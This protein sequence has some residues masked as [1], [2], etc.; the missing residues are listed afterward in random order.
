MAG[1]RT[2]DQRLRVFVSSTMKELAAER[3]AVRDSVQRLRLTPVLFELG[4]R[5]HPPRALYQAYLEQSDVFVGIYWQ[6]YGWVAPSAEISGLEDEYRLSGHR[7]R[8]LYVKDPAPDRDP[9]L[10]SLLDEI[11][12]EASLS[13]RSFT[14]A[15]ELGELVENDLAHL[16]S[17]RFAADAD[18]RPDEGRLPAPATPLVGRDEE[19]AVVCSLLRGDAR[20]VTVTGPGGIGKTRVGIR[21]AE[22]L[23]ADFDDGAVFVDLA[24]ADAE[25]V[26]ELIAR[27]VGVRDTSVD[28][29]LVRLRRALRE[30]QL[31]LCL[32]C[33]ERVVPAAGVVSEVL[34]A[35][36]RSKVLVTSREL[37]RLRG[38]HELRLRPLQEAHAVA[39]FESRARAAG[40]AHDDPVGVAH[41]C[42]RLD[43]MPLALELVAPQTRLIPPSAMLARLEGRFDLAGARDLPE[44]Q[45]TLRRTLEW[46]YELLNE[47]EQLA[48]RRL[49][50]FPTAGFALEW[51]E[52]LLG[53]EVEAIACIDALL[54]KSLLS[55]VG[56]GAPR[57]AML[58]AV[59]DYGLE[60]LA[61][62]G[63]RAMFEERHAQLVA[64]FAV[65]AGRELWGPDQVSWLD[66][67]ELERDN[68][69]AAL[70]WAEVNDARLLVELVRRL[71]WFWEVRGH[72]TEGLRWVD[73][74][75]SA[76]EGLESLDRVDTLVAAASLV[77]FKG[78]L[79]REQ[80]WG[81]E[82]LDLA[83]RLGDLPATVLPLHILGRLEL[84]Y[85]RIEAARE[86]YV[87]ALEI[88]PGEP[89]L[90]VSLSVV[91]TLDGNF[92]RAVE[93]ARRGLETWR[94]RGNVWSVARALTNLAIAT[95]RGGDPERAVPMLREAVALAHELG[96]SERLAHALEDLA[97]VLLQLDRAEAAAHL[98][99]AVRRIRTEVGLLEGALAPY[100]TRVDDA[101]ATLGERL[102]TEAWQAGQALTRD[103]AAAYAATA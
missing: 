61:A 7:P 36:P 53:T 56:L 63:E 33:F 10:A 54:A 38:E 82:A 73:A 21:A 79:R 5:P 49:A 76:T 78:D 19:V 57:L 70:A 59:R 93:L 15:E 67:L 34:E 4:A 69:A 101:R 72:V 6:Q 8:L 58:E 98:Y 22:Q 11:R 94:A 30:R 96:D 74:A 71:Y 27:A 46:D 17:E 14:S 48:Y 44:R 47:A 92:L 88:S 3:A 13:Y 25:A 12:A 18:G 91:E 51:A 102:F 84:E 20:L 23:A 97:G 40:S 37:L 103:E 77:R 2:P 66:R 65:E 39:L 81:E 9:R 60:R 28:A 43:C 64:R 35:S 24:A 45:R 80:D 52:T 50:V 89:E 87:E 42:R 83:R 62:A 32:D 55:T 26:P 86:R 68:L 16:L 95:A 99:G 31:F 1:I 75:V 41:L 100:Y 29:P 85:T 90:L